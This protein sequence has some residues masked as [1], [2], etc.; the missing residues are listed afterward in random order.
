M[1]TSEFGSLAFIITLAR[2]SW[3]VV[4]GLERFARELA[5]LGESGFLKG[6]ADFVRVLIQKRLGLCYVVLWIA[7]PGAENGDVSV[8]GAQR[9]LHEVQLVAMFRRL[10][11]RYDRVVV[12]RAVGILHCLRH[13]DLPTMGLIG[14]LHSFREPVQFR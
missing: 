5:H 10:V 2:S 7:N 9:G 3:F 8:L 4:N 11:K 14:R 1:R 12:L 6:L 13:E